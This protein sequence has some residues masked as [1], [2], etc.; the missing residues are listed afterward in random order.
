MGLTDPP[1][2][3]FSSASFSPRADLGSIFPRQVPLPTG[4]LRHRCP[5][6]VGRAVAALAADPQVAKKSGRVF[7]SWDLAQEYGFRDVDGR[8]PNWGKHVEGKYG[9]YKM[10]DKGFYEY[11]FGG[12]IATVYPNWP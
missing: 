1:A 7:S 9:R 2:T 11:W 4:I 10:C 6:Y 8:Q 3:L 5:F 12:L